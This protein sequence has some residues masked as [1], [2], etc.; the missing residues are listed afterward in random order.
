MSV[1]VKK[2]T[3]IKSNSNPETVGKVSTSSKKSNSKSSSY[4]GNVSNPNYNSDGTKKSSSSSS[5]SAGSYLNPAPNMSTEAGP[6][7]AP[8]PQIG[9]QPNSPLKQDSPISGA[10]DSPI[11]KFINEQTGLGPL[12]DLISTDANGKQVIDFE[13]FVNLMN[14]GPTGN[15]MTDEGMI[16]ASGIS[17]PGMGSFTK[18]T[19]DDLVKVGSLDD[20]VDNNVLKYGQKAGKANVNTKTVKMVKKIFSSKFSQK[21]LA[22]AGAWAGA[23]FLGKWGQAEAPEPLGITM[24]S[25][26]IP[27]AQKTGDWS[28]V[29][30]A[31]AARDEILDLNWWEKVALWSPISPAIG[32]PAKIKGAITAAKV[33]DKLIDDLKIQQETGESDDDKWARIREEQSSQ[34]KEAINYYNQQRKL[35][36]EW[37]RDAEVNARNDDA[38][39]WAEQRAKQAELEAADRKA[40]AD[41]WTAYRKQAAKLAADNSPSK[42]NFGLI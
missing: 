35:M 23:V 7:Y 8:A 33:Q 4:S 18:N 32:I 9:M 36:V 38:A 21:A 30:E 28:L 37:E 15:Q 14:Q 26:L 3:V 10:G 24:N 39:F 16:M 31:Q 12:K 29:N 2:G 6:V 20:F 17:V 1:I 13:G 40:I 5:S 11:K 27:N 19:I 34:D 25:M 22:W 41:F 42:L